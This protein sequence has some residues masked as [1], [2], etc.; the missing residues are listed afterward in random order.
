[1]LEEGWLLLPEE[2]ALAD[3]E[4]LGH[5]FLGRKGRRFFPGHGFSDGVIVGYLSSALND[6]IELWHIRHDD[7]D[8]EDLEEHEVLEAFRALESEETTAGIDDSGDGAEEADSEMASV[9]GGERLWTTAGVREK[10]QDA[11]R[12]S[13]T[14]GELSLALLSFYERCLGFGVVEESI[15]GRRGSARLYSAPQPAR[16]SSMGRRSL[17]SK[18][19]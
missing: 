9:E 15:D 5:E 3:G 1:M 8:G 13:R 18:S 2:Q 14:V 10:W 6:G 19:A 16:R 11:V 7:G 4:D 17:R 12:R